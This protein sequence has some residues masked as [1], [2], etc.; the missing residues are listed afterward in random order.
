ME[1]QLLCL[2]VPTFFMKDCGL[3][4]LLLAISNKSFISTYVA[5]AQLNNAV[6]FA[7]SQHPE[8]TKLRS[9]CYAIALNA[10]TSSGSSPGFEIFMRS[11]TS[12]D[13]DFHKDPNP[14]EL[15]KAD[16]PLRHLLQRISQLR[17]AFF[18]GNSILISIGQVCG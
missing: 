6:V 1:K 10:R 3:L 15:L 11:D 14:S 13:L 4:T 17:R 8:I 7:D 5:A 12:I 2:K 18:P 9:H 16:V